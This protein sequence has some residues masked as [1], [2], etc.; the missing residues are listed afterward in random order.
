VDLRARAS[1]S[2]VGCEPANPSAGCSF[3]QA[4]HF[5]LCARPFSERCP[6]V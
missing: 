4:S 1:E 3:S 2:G 6:S 5:T